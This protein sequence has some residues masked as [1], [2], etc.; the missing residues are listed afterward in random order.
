MLFFW[1]SRK[2]LTEYHMSDFAPSFS[3]M[4]LPV[5]LSTG[6]NLFWQT[7]NKLHGR[8]WNPIIV[9]RGC[10]RS[11]SRICYWSYSLSA[12]HQLYTRHARW[13]FIIH[14]PLCWRLCHLSW[15]P[16]WY[17]LQYSSARPPEVVNYLA[18]ELQ[19]E[20][21]WSDVNHTKTSTKNVP[22]LPS[23]WFNS[24]SLGV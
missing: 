20:E 22:V 13:H 5:I 1:T 16:V 10:I 2:P 12:F 9:E 18:Y 4:A 8:W 14:S 7:E 6:Y 17:R 15:D 21:M 24:K 11:S 3:I 23:Q 19:C